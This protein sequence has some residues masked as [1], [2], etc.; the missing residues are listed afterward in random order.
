MFLRTQYMQA[1]RQLATSLAAGLVAGTPASIIP[2]TA[3][4]ALFKS[5]PAPTIDSVITDY[6]ECDF[7]GYAKTPITAGGAPINLPDGVGVHKEVNFTMSGAATAPQDALGM[8]LVDPAGP[9]L[10]GVELFD[11]P[12]NFGIAG[13]TLSYDLILAPHSNWGGEQGA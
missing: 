10:L 11:Q 4:V 7:P 6:V 12:A 2:T 9:T 8:M 3:E 5:G 13:D 1:T